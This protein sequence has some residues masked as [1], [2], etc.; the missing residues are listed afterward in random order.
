MRLVL[1][2]FFALAFLITGPDIKAQN[3]KDRV[4]ALRVA[5]IAK[6]LELSATESEKF[7]PMYNEFNDKLEA[8]RKNARQNIMKRPENPGD[9]EAEEA[10]KADLQFKQAEADLYKQY[11]EKI[12]AAI[13][14]KKTAR[15]RMAEYEFKKMML[16]KARGNNKGE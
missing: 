16:D 3:N 1:Y 7:W 9:A 5:Y 12:K 8:L 15:L 13:G 2:I 6:R 14:V 4:E 11:S 10:Y